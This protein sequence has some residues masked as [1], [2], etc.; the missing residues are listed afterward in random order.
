MHI[1]KEEKKEGGGGPVLAKLVKLADKLYN[2]RDLERHIPPAF[3]KQG[4]REY[5]NW[6]K[7]VVFQLK[8]TNEA[9]EMALDDVINRFLEK[10]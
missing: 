10:Q 8:G 1:L 9:L 6:A 4:A 5:F 2:L 7:K 3:G